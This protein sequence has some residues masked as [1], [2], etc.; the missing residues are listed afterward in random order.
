MCREL[1]KTYEEVRRGSLG[2]LTAW[3]AEGVRGEITVVISGAVAVVASLPDAVGAVLG[4]VAEGERLKDAVVE[5]ATASGL[6]KSA[7]YD[8]ALAARKG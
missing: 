2:E 4:R 7:L 8:A 3:A 5:V 1:T 6:S